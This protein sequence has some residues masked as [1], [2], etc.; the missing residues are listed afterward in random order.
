MCPWDLVWSMYLI[1]PKLFRLE[2]KADSFSI[3][4][5]DKQ[6]IIESA[7]KYLSDW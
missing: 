3:H 7:E 6:K 5:E 1:E 4:I 2:K